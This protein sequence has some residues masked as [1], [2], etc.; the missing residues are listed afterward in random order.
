[1]SE[2]VK[3]NI[4][5]EMDG[6][7]DAERVVFLTS[8]LKQLSADKDQDCDDY[9]KEV[10][11]RFLVT[12]RLAVAEFQLTEL[13]EQVESRQATIEA[14]EQLW[15]DR[16]PEQ[17]GERE[18]W[19]RARLEAANRKLEDQEEATSRAVRQAAELRDRAQKAEAELATVK[20][21]HAK[22]HA[23]MCGYREANGEMSRRIAELEKVIDGLRA[24]VSHS[25]MEAPDAVA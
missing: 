13:R 14:H 24:E 10:Q 25:T 4:L 17:A 2:A 1:M 15:A 12:A 8:I 19:L 11:E 6:L 16:E 20:L 7:A 21:Q 22:D 23:A 9:I 3:R 5:V 18:Q